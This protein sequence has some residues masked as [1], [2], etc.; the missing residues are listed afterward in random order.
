MAKSKALGPDVLNLC[1]YQELPIGATAVDIDPYGRRTG[2]WRYNRP[3][4]TE[5]IPPCQNSCPLGNW[6]QKFVAEL[7]LENL[8]EAW[9][10]LKLENPFP[11]VCGRVCSHTC[12]EVCNRGDLGG[13]VSIKRLERFL[14]DHFWNGLGTPIKPK[15]AQGK[16]IAVLG[17]GPAGMAG[18]YFLTLMGYEITLFESHESLGGIPRI[19]IPDYRLPKEILEKEIKDILSLGIEVKTGCHLGNGIS[20]EELLKFDGVFLATGAH[21]ER[22]LG[23][24]G[25]NVEGVFRGWEFLKQCN[26]KRITSLGEKVLVIGGGNL[27]TDVARS[28]IR[29]GRTPKVIYRRTRQQMP[30]LFDEIEEAIEEG[31]EFHFLLSPVAIHQEKKNGL[32]L[33]CCEVELK[34][35][36]ESGRPRPVAIEGAR[37]YFDA[38]QIIIATGEDPN[39]SYLPKEFRRQKDSLWVNEWGQTS[40]P[41]VFAGGDMVDIPRTVTHA[42]GSAK[43]AAIAMDHF[44]KGFNL[45][46]G[47][48]MPQTMRECLGLADHKLEYLPEAAKLEDLNVIYCQPEERSLPCKIPMSQRV[49]SFQE[50]NG[51]FSLKEALREAKRCLSCGVCKMCGNCYLFCPD[52][53]VQLSLDGDRYDINYEYCKG[54][55]ICQKECPVGAINIKVEKEE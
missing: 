7:A 27:A 11:G 52:G 20:A 39:L 36:D 35:I 48:A 21:L 41:H 5:K 28:L 30:A 32:R 50:V 38:D 22:S 40:V 44:L 10:T 42:I 8:E 54:C 18:A 26:S 16:R 2:L 46:K 23:I 47:D 53:T 1:T 17:S 55:G 37:R 9:S 12:E 29:L 14:S 31:T 51:G 43:R 19:G 45:T 6:V 33:E 13:S 24:P 34:G 25:E 49:K 15:V 4:F 3:Y